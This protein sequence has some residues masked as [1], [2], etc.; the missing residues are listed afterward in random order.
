MKLAF[1][2]TLAII[3]AVEIY[4][5]FTADL[6]MAKFFFTPFIVVATT[7]TLVDIAEIIYDKIVDYN[8]CLMTYMFPPVDDDDDIDTPPRLR[9]K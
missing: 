4:Y 3:I 1:A 8:E 2:I 7:S 5:L 6:E 9:N